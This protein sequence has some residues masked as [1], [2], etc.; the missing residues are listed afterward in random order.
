MVLNMEFEFLYW[1][2]S[3]HTPWLD[4]LM[5]AVTKLGNGGIFW[6]MVGLALFCVP[7]TRRCGLAVLMSLLC[8]LLVGNVVL[9]NLF[10]RPRPCWLDETIVLLIDN[11]KDFSFPSGHS[12]ASFEAAMSIYF[13]H[14]KWG[15]GALILAAA[16]ACSRMYLFVHFP[17]D[18]LAGSLLGIGIAWLVHQCLEQR[19]ERRQRR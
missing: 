5:T 8:G 3:L 17:T 7:K 14:K 2:Q 4:S 19:A 11:P 15:I 12:L 18:V 10:A 6:I 16:I 13:Y 9:K 1:L